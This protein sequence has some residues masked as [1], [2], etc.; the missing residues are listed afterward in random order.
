MK[1]TTVTQRVFGK[2]IILKFRKHIIR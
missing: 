2:G 1:N